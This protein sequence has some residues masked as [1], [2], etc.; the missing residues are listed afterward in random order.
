MNK[1]PLF[2]SLFMLLNVSPCNSN[3]I[4]I[5]F[6]EL[7]KYLGKPV[8]RNAQRIDVNFWTIELFDNNELSENINLITENN[9]VVTAEY[10]FASRSVGSLNQMRGSFI[11][12]FEQY[13]ENRI[14]NNNIFFWEAKP[15]SKLGNVKR[16]YIAL[17]KVNVNNE[18]KGIWDL[19]VSILELNAVQEKIKKVVEKPERHT[20]APCPPPIPRWETPSA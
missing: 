19:R 2:I 14:S 1:V 6:N 7:E 10:F 9:I 20:P 17:H 5:S 4:I 18:I 3:E 15:N 16:L 12:I 13:C 11:D 8:P